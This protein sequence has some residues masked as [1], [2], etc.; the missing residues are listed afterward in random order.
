MT[1]RYAIIGDIIVEQ[2]VNLTTPGGAGAIA[3]AL[4]DIDGQVTLRSVIS[5]D[6][7]GKTILEELKKARIHP[8]LV[9]RV[10]DTPL[11]RITRDDDGAITERVPGVGIE[12]GAIM[13]IYALFGHD[14]LIL[15]TRDQP[16]RRFITDLP[17]HTDGN[18]KMISTLAHLDWNEPTADEIDIA[19][20]CD[21]IIGTPAH[22]EALTGQADVTDAL[23][24]LF[25][26][27]P[28]TQLRAA[29]AITPH[30]LD[31]VARE[32]RV[33]RPVRDAIPDLLLPQVT[34][35]IAWGL[36]HYAPWEDAAT[37]AVDPTFA[38]DANR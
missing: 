29:V 23:G 33:L 1:K 11:P 18:V 9:D 6:P 24:D 5:T 20:R 15:D 14:A 12:K 27:M 38:L 2:H 3:L 30:G 37:T 35:G 21:A 10:D 17:A 26:R 31:L 36:A 4:R 19:M 32:D 7:I 16:L 8:G 25:D 34:A 13:D 28:G 22:F